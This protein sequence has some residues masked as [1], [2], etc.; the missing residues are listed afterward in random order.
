MK[1]INNDQGSFF[2]A[3]AASNRNTVIITDTGEYGCLKVLANADKYFRGYY[4]EFYRVANDLSKKKVTNKLLKEIFI[5]SLEMNYRWT[6]A[7]R[8]QLAHYFKIRLDSFLAEKK[9]PKNYQ[10]GSSN[11]ARDKQRKALP[12]GKRVSKSGR[13]YTER[14]KNHSDARP[15]YRL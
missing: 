12:P 5:H 10:T 11:K 9:R 7:E 6:V 3:N 1:I 13:T 15:K 14:R 2:V 8:E 4:P